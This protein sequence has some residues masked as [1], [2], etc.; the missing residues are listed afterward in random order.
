MA[1][2]RG[3]LSNFGKKKAPPFKGKPAPKPKSSGKK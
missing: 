3:K 2:G 1:K